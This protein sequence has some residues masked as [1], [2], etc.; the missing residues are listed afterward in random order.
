MLFEHV[1]GVL[2]DRLL[3]DFP[4]EDYWDS[5]PYR[6]FELK[7]LGMVRILM[8]KETSKITCPVKRGGKNLG[9]SILLRAWG[10]AML[11]ITQNHVKRIQM[12]SFKPIR[13]AEHI[14]P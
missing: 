8:M 12:V 14:T 11:W 7:K 3:P 5:L 2:R 1:W 10:S 6:D 9:S 13:Q 4:I